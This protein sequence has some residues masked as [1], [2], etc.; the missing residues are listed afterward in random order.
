VDSGRVGVV[1]TGFGATTPLGPDAVSTWSAVLAGKSG[2]VS[3]ST[4]WADELPSRIAAPAA[5]D[6]LAALD[7]VRARKTDRCQQLALVAAREAWQHAGAPDVIPERLG[8]SVSSGIGGL[9]S[10]LDAYDVLKTKG[11]R[12]VSPYTNP[13]QMANGPAAWISIELNAR[14]GVHA[15]VSACASGAE[16]IGYGIEMIRSGRADVVLAGGAEAC[17]HPLT[18]A[19]FAA[20]RAL[21]GRNDE[22]QRASR[23]FDKGRDGFVL[24]EGAG[25]VVLE[26]LAHAAARGAIVHAVAAGVGYSASAHHITH[27]HPD[28]LDAARAIERALVDARVEQAQLVHVNAHASSTPAGDRAEALAIRRALGDVG[29]RVIVSATKSMTGHLLGAA[30]AVEQVMTICALRD[31]T[32]PPTINLEDL[33]DEVAEA[34][35]KIA[36][37][38]RELHAGHGPAAALNNSYGF[39]GHHV[40]LILVEAE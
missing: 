10:T 32:A 16:A 6:P 26:S 19:A 30:G 21:S 14:A 39:G 23:P 3:L 29:D 2:V 12:R 5:A 33:D 38:P 11:W 27:A 1:I 24:G 7:R 18:I 4:C 13:M 15:P 40:S 22:P 20:M 8:V 9:I 17:I 28:G 31:R 25:I 34:G 35:I 36:T 37:G